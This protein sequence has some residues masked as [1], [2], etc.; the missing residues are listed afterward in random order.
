MTNTNPT[1]VKDVLKRLK[2][3][4]PAGVTVEKGR[5]I[6]VLLHGHKVGTCASTPSDRRALLNFVSDL[7]RNGVDLRKMEVAARV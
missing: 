3:L 2:A 7:R 5:H 1:S 4:E 6:A